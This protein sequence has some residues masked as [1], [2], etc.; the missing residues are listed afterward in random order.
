MPHNSFDRANTVIQNSNPEKK[1]QWPRKKS[2]SFPNLP[3]FEET[4]KYSR[5]NRK[6]SR[7][8]NIRPRSFSN[9]SDRSTSGA[10]SSTSNNHDMK[11]DSKKIYRQMLEELYEEYGR[12]YTASDLE[13]LSE[14]DDEEN[15]KVSEEEEVEQRENPIKLLIEYLAIEHEYLL[16]L[17][18]FLPLI[19]MACYIRFV[20]DSPLYVE[21]ETT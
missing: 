14:D 13:R 5:L 18:V 20:E 19:L 11:L 7:Q 1:Q 9:E 17:I 4:P 12:Q 3:S 10:T 15:E 6:L 21:L 8:D 16:S 2:L